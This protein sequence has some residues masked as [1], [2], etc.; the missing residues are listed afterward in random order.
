MTKPAARTRKP[1]ELSGVLNRNLSRYALAA[2]AAG[3]GLL[4]LAM[5]SEAEIV[6]TKVDRLIGRGQSYGIDLNHDG[7]VDF[8]IHNIFN[9]CTRSFTYCPALEIVAFPANGNEIEYGV[10][11]W[12]AAALRPGAVIGSGV[13]MN[14]AQEFMADEFRS[15]GAFYYFGSWL[16]VSN[17][18]LGLRFQ[19]NGETHYGWAR[20]TVR[21]REKYRLTAFLSD[22]AYETQAN[23]PI[24]ASDTGSGSA[25]DAGSSPVS[26]MFSGPT[27]ETN[28]T[29]TLG[30]LALGAGGLAIW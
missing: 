3:V 15:W 4:S 12:Y 30:L 6:Y 14:N 8:S 26:E 5:P 16:G 21:S 13:P 2:S 27:L 23:K 28:S 1:A 25:D 19:M 7:I 22:F 10:H 11:P 17:R 24:I 20:L 29:A 9:G 18:F